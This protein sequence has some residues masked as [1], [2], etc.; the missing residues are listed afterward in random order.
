LEGGHG[1]GRAAGE[2]R[3]EFPTTG[4]NATGSAI[5]D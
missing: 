5:D 3:F 1:P 2:A 4:V